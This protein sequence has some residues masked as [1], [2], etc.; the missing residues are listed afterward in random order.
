VDNQFEAFQSSDQVLTIHGEYQQAEIGELLDK[1]DVEL[2]VY[3]SAGPETFCYTLTEAWSAGIPAL[4]PPIGALAERVT[5][6]QAGWLMTDWRDL[7]AILD[8]I[9]SILDSR[10]QGEFKTRQAH[11]RLAHRYSVDEMIEDTEAIY[12]KVISP[13]ALRSAKSTSPAVLLEAARAAQ[14]DTIVATGTSLPVHSWPVRMILYIR[15]SRL[16]K[17]LVEFVPMGL[18]RLLKRIF[19]D[20]GIE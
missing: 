2:A 16:G 11:A 6:V 9:L 18:R 13:G 15:E 19:L 20:S 7:D 12:S 8:D 17:K 14:V 1:Y 10:Q 3:P 4:V 5:N